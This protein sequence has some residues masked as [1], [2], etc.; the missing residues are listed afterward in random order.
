MVLQSTAACQ[1][2]PAGALQRVTLHDRLGWAQLLPPLGRRATKKQQG[3]TCWCD[4]T[5]TDPEAWLRGYG[6]GLG[7]R[8]PPGALPPPRSPS[9]PF[10]TCPR[11]LC[12][13]PPDHRLSP[14][15]AWRHRQLRI[16][17]EQ[18]EDRLTWPPRKSGTWISNGDK[19]HAEEIQKC[20]RFPTSLR[21]SQG[22]SR[23]IRVKEE[24]FHHDLASVDKLCPAQG[25]L[26]GGTGDRRTDTV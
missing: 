18:G 26:E 8:V 7:P 6:H 14:G 23:S 15:P 2:R 1:L 11:H 5:T 10:G 20:D 25:R 12:K 19:K 4:C 13:A 21:A 24:I 17:S 3:V 9:P 16:S 22:I